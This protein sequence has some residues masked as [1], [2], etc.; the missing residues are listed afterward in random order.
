MGFFRKF[1]RIYFW[2]WF[3]W[4]FVKKNMPNLKVY[5][6]LETVQWILR[7]GGSCV[8][9]GDGEI[10]MLMGSPGPG[11]QKTSETLRKRL[12]DVL[13]KRDDKLLICIPRAHQIDRIPALTQ[14]AQKY[15]K[16]YVVKT[17]LFALKNFDQNYQYGDGQMSRPYMDTHNVDLCQKVFDGIKTIFKDQDIVIVEGGKTRLGVGNDMLNDARSVKRIIAPSENAFEKSDVIFEEIKK[18]VGKESLLLFAIGPAS[19]PLIIDL[20]DLGY[21]SLDLGHLD[22][23]YEWFLQRATKKSPVLGKDIANEVKSAIC[24][25]NDIDLTKYREEIIARVE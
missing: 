16:A 15:W 9:L 5:D 11:Y 23:E 14:R 2:L 13:K 8:R 3:V 18:N 12:F 10:G 17:R 19:K 24:N 1:I 20:F 6:P 21:R 22:I 4:P 7:T 25:D